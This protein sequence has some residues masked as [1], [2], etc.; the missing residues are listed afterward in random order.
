[1]DI[2]PFEIRLLVRI[3]TRRT[4]RPIHDDDL[5]QD[6]TLKAVEAFGKQFEVRHPR[7]FLRKIVC[8]TVRDHWRRR[9]P[10]EGLNTIDE[11][12]FAESPRF[13]ERLDLQ[14]RVALLRAGLAQLDAGKRTTL[15]MFYVDELPVSEIARLQGKSVSAVKMEMLRARRLLAGILR[16][17]AEGKGSSSSTPRQ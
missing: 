12:Y 8:D 4:G 9:R 3:A 5:V 15:H 10:A 6:A 17:L 7:A 16:D 1:M 11:M 14:R 2:D 13:E